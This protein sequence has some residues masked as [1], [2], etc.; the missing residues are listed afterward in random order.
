MIPPT[1]YSLQQYGDQTTAKRAL[2]IQFIILKSDLHGKLLGLFQYPEIKVQ[3]PE[4]GLRV[5]TLPHGELPDHTPSWPA[6][7][8]YFSDR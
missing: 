5:L 7:D 1:L 6:V 8:W 2:Q 4:N 3:T